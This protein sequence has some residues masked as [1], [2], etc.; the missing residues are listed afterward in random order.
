MS[1]R[2]LVLLFSSWNPVSLASLRSSRSLDSLVIFILSMCLMCLEKT[3][4]THMH[5]LISCCH[6]TCTDGETEA[7][8]GR[9]LSQ[10]IGRAGADIAPSAQGPV[11]VS[12]L[13]PPC[14]SSLPLEIRSRLFDAFLPLL[15]LFLLSETLSLNTHLLPLLTHAQPSGHSLGGQLG[16]GSPNCTLSATATASPFFLFPQWSISCLSLL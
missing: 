14:R 2:S 5:G 11:C 3:V 9:L 7:H 13:M 6:H 1:R 12:D 15:T 8:R 16:Q 4:C 10:V